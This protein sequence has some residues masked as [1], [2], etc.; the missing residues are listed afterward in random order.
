MRRAI[1]PRRII[2][3]TETP[4][5]GPIIVQEQTPQP[6]R[7]DNPVKPVAGVPWRTVTICHAIVTDTSLD[8]AT[9]IEQAELPRHAVVGGVRVEA[10]CADHVLLRVEGVPNALP[11]LPMYIGTDGWRG[12][13]LAG[14]DGLEMRKRPDVTAP[15]RI[16]PGWSATHL[17]S[18]VKRVVDSR[19]PE[20]LIPLD[21]PMYTAV[22]LPYCSEHA[23]AAHKAQPHRMFDDLFREMLRDRCRPMAGGLA[24]NMEYFDTAMNKLISD[25]ARLVLVDGLTT[26]AVKLRRLTHS[27]APVTMQFHVDL[28]WTE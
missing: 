20:V 28:W 17:T 24:V 14:T 2:R 9:A 27:T 21:H 1:Q 6:V 18:T 11:D 4:A 13:M 16:P 26:V 15:P 8:L 23:K 12:T 3:T 22:I 25:D 7:I 5:E 10:H 19:P